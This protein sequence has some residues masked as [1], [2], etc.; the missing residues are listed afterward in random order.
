MTDSPAS[1]ATGEF[2]RWQALDQWLAIHSDVWRPAPFATPEPAWTHRYPEMTGYLEALDDDAV[3]R[4]ESDTSALVAALARWLPDLAIRNDLL[5]LSAL[6][7]EPCPL[8]EVSAVDMPGR[9]REQAG[10]FTAALGPLKHPVLDWCCGKGHLARTLAQLA[11]SALEGYEWNRQLVADGN[12]LAQRYGDPVTLYTQDVLDNALSWPA[13]RHAVA[14]HACGDLH[15]R[16][17]KGASKHRW[18]RVSISP[19]CFHLTQNTNYQPLSRRA[20]EHGINAALSR[21]D[22]RLAVRETVTAPARVRRQTEV[23]QVWRLGFDA[24]QRAVRGVN[25]Y[26]PVPP[27]SPA[28]NEA[29]FEAFCRWAA[30]KKRI[31]LPDDADFGYWLALGEQRQGQVRRH[32]LLRHLF[33]RPLEVWMVLDYALYFEEQGYRV[34]LGTFCQRELTPRNLLL[35]ATLD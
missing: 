4:F 18:P 15:R 20:R 12:A 13:R 22:I 32:E 26:L 16:L 11:P 28:L 7:G 2:V 19:C 25:D 5:Q 27:H 30:A 1:D 35:D 31:V 3:N 9:K 10:A 17:I 24:L 29:G 34:R 6:G 8:P 33:R 21:Q 14:L 23:S